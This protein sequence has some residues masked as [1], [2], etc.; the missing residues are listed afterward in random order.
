MQV[1][2][3]KRVNEKRRG[4]LISVFLARACSQH[5]TGSRTHPECGSEICGHQARITSCL[6]VITQRPYSITN[7]LFL[8][9]LMPVIG[10]QLLGLINRENRYKYCSICRS[11]SGSAHSAPQ[12][13]EHYLGI[14]WGLRR[15]HH[16]HPKWPDSD[17]M[18]VKVIS[19]TV[20]VG[21]SEGRPWSS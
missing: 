12:Y 21:T 1:R 18:R 15:A 16:I 4:Q 2:L 20:T 14:I 19:S 17:R 8:A 6:Y 5:L 13:P 11:R 3:R 7:Q 9:L 10:G